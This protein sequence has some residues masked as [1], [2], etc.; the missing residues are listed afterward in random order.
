MLATGLAVDDD[1]AACPG[2]QQPQRNDSVAL[3]A[4][5]DPLG[6]ATSLNAAQAGAW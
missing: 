1:H 4:G 6:Q 5:G 2:L 3:L